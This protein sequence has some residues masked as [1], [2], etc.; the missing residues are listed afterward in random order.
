MSPLSRLLPSGRPRA[1]G[2]TALGVYAGSQKITGVALQ[3]QAG[4]PPRVAAAAA[5]EGASA[6][7]HWVAWAARHQARSRSTVLLHGGHYRILP[8][9][10]PR[11]P[12]EERRAAVRFQA[13]EL[14]D[15]S[16][17][18]TSVDCVDVPSAVHGQAASRVFVVAGLNQEVGR[19]MSRYRA[20]KLELQAIDIPEMAL[21]NLSSLAA[22]DSAHLYLHVGLNSARMVIVWRQELCAFRHF[23]LSGRDIHNADDSSIEAQFDQ[24]ALDVQRTADAFGRQFHGADLQ[25]LW[26]SSV[27]RLDTVVQALSGLLALP[28]KRLVI[29]ELVDWRAE[30]PAL[31]HD[32]GLDHTLALGA[33]LR[34]AAA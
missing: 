19:W 2:A 23:E 3:R 24:L 9:D 26:V 31:D 7:E 28:V 14:L 30:Q 1:T 5:F 4:Q 17:D 18:E 25:A 15:F 10:A 32:A 29:E 8:L 20:A 12:A 6:A 11:V 34:T 16:V 33:A 27:T 22:G 13:Q 21:R